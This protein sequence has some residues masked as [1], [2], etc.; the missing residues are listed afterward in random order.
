[1]SISPITCGEDL[2]QFYVKRVPRMFVDY[3]ESG[4]WTE[5]TLRRNLDDFARIQFHQRVGVGV[6][7]F[8]QR[9]TMLGQDVALSVVLAP[10]GMCGNATRRRGD[11]GVARRRTSTCRSRSR[12]WACV[13]SKT[14]QRSPR[15]HSGFSCIYCATAI[16]SRGSSIARKRRVARRWC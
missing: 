2:R 3:Y 15:V 8:S 4:S 9:T 14:F 10:V 5:S 16:S 7:Q 11:A 13:R 1:M 6:D 12:L